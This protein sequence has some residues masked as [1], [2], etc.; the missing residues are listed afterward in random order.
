MQAEVF[1]LEKNVIVIIILINF[2][3]KREFNH[4]SNIF[5]TTCIISVDAL[6]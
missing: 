5:R 1:I 6:L 2:T 4:I 3:E